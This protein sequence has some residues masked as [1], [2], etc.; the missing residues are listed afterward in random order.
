MADAQGARCKALVVPFAYPVDEMNDGCMLC[1]LDVRDLRGTTS[2]YFAMTDA[3]DAPEDVAGGK[4][5][6]LKFVGDTATVAVPGIQHPKTREYVEVP[7]KVVANRADRAV[8]LE[9][10]DQSV[11]LA[12]NTWSDWFEWTFAVTPKFSVRAISRVHVLEVGEQVRLYMTC[13]QYHPRAPY[14][15]ISHPGEYSAEL[16]EQGRQI[17]GFMAAFHAELPYFTTLQSRKRSTVHFHRR[18]LLDFD[19]DV[20]NVYATG[21][22]AKIATIPLP[23]FRTTWARLTADGKLLLLN[24]RTGRCVVV[25]TDVQAMSAKSPKSPE[26]R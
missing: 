16:V 6:P 23:P 14:V 12:E 2:T 13:L 22:P 26:R 17:D 21:A 1:G 24:H 15:P 7:V 9:V 18:Q 10:Q 8:R 11:T 3:I 4:R 19:V 25:Q 20:L 5:L